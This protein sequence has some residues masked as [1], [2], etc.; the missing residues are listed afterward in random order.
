MPV[1]F[2][3]KTDYDSSPKDSELR[4]RIILRTYENAR[5]SGDKK[6][7]FIDGQHLYGTDGRDCCTVDGCHPNDLG[8]YRIAQNVYPYIKEALHSIK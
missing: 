3:S 5:K 4:K 1:V 2:M 7:W 8:F 6:V